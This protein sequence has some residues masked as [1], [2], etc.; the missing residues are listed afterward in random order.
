MP[1]NLRKD[2]MT[3]KLVIDKIEDVPEPIRDQYT[4][5]DG[6]FHL[7]V[8]NAEAESIFAAPLKKVIDSERKLRA[9]SDARVRAWEK[10]GKTPEEIEALIQEQMKVDE[11]KL[12]RAG[13]WDKLKAQMN[14]RHKAELDA[15]AKKLTDKEAEAQSKDKALEELLIESHAAAAI[16]AA[17]GKLKA[18]M[19]HVKQHLRLVRD[20][21]GS[22]NANYT[23][24]VVDDA[25]GPRVNGKGDPLTVADLIAELRASD[26]FGGL[27]DGTGNSGSGMRPGSASG[28]ANGAIGQT[29]RSDFKNEKERAAF[30]D[31]FGLDEYRKLPL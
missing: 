29:K 14:E 3:L 15:V 27:F 7:N 9:A 10:S 19:P 28:G 23:L 17:K 1:E 11:E 5:K 4:E 24:K 30:I 6:K 2:A 22:G 12:Q 20:Q 26:D 8:D 25:G 21:N 13:E 31:Q 16:S 18:L